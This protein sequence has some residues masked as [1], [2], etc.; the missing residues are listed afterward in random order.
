MFKSLDYIAN[1][2]IDA[3]IIYEKQMGSSFQN[4]M[5]LTNISKEF[6][7][8]NTYTT[9]DIFNIWKD[10]RV[11]NF[12]QDKYCHTP[13]LF[14]G[15]KEIVGFTHIKKCID[16]GGIFAT[17][18]FG[19]YRYIPYYLTK[20][21]NI[22]SLHISTDIDTYN[23]EKRLAIWKECRKIYPVKDILSEKICTSTTFL[24]KMNKGE[25]IILCL[26]DSIKSNET[27]D[28]IN[29][30]HLSSMVKMKINVF[31][32]IYFSKK[33]MC[34]LISDRNEEGLSRLTAYPHFYI[35][36]KDN[37]KHAANYSYHLFQTKLETQ[38]QLWS[39]WCKHHQ[40]VTKWNELPVGTTNP[41]IDWKIDNNALGLDIGTGHIHKIS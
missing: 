24:K 2:Y 40:N 39:L 27:Y 26:D 33:P 16:E 12:I 6:L 34:I 13:I 41:S 31:K 7:P 29:I 21:V 5:T 14:E 37:I 32:L 4:F 17:Y 30:K 8:L 35:L 25:S 19:D 9:K 20:L 10:Y 23:K 38:P 15:F 1:K 28:I 3:E 18:H 36:Q 11:Y 22:D